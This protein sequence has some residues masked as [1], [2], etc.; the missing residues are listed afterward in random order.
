MVRSS[1]DDALG[2]VSGVGARDHHKENHMGRERPPRHLTPKKRLA[3]A[4][5]IA[6]GTVLLPV[7]P[8]AAA[9]SCGEYS[10]G[11]EGTR[12]LNDGISDSAGP[13]AIDLPA[14]T[15]TVTLVSSDHHSTQTTSQSQLAE[16]Y[17]VVLDSGYVSPPSADI[18]DS[19]DS[20]TTTH[21]GQVIDASSAISVRHLGLPG[22]NSVNVLCVGFTTEA[23]ADDAADDA[24]EEA[25]DDASSESDGPVADEAPASDDD[26]SDGA[27]DSDEQGAVE[28]PAE[29]TQD[30]ADPVSLVRD[31]PQTDA[32]A[33]EIV[34]P[35]VEGVVEERPVQLAIT[36]PSLAQVLVLLGVSMIAL[37]VGLVSRERRHLS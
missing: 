26:G 28:P 6:L 18:P 16:Q 10:Y 32:P 31:P 8:A 9:T 13:F 27:D 12:L 1:R 29:Q 3:A 2:I 21:V 25:E 11:F 20:V 24:T 15:Y 19:V 17:V 22:I 33:L 4:A 23:S 14:G 36:G 34:E 5:L 35:E 30:I 7:A 37:G